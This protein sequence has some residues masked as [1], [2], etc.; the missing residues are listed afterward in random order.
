MT[1]TQSLQS[2]GAKVMV[3]VTRTR[4]LDPLSSEKHRA[5][6][7]LFAPPPAPLH[8]NDFCTSPGFLFESLRLTTITYSVVGNVL[9][10]VGSPDR[11]AE[12]D[13]SPAAGKTT[14]WKKNLFTPDGETFLT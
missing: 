12:M 2:Q 3:E 8:Q 4:R 9:E 7:P 13:D 5:V 11:G 10:N 14:K 1:Y 6:R